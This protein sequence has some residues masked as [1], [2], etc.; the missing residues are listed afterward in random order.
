MKKTIIIIALF[1]LGF[2]ACQKDFEEKNFKYRVSGLEQPYTVI[3]M[4]ETGMSITEQVSPQSTGD[5]WSAS[6]TGRQGDILYLYVKYFDVNPPDDKFRMYIEVDGKMLRYADEYDKDDL[7]M[8]ID[9]TVVPH[10]TIYTPVFYV[11]RAG[12]IPY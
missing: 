9:T 10:D 3:Y 1:A 2:A 6:F 11:K 8:T 5:I 7:L 12:I 4:D